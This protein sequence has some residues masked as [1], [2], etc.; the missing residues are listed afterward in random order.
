MFAFALDEIA[1]QAGSAIRAKLR[2]LATSLWGQDPFARGSYSY[3]VPGQAGARDFLAAPN[4]ERIFFAGE[5]VA[6]DYFGTAHGAGATGVAAA[7][8]ALATLR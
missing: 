6:G 3:A 8:H 5:A 4:L 7:E 1:A 2:P